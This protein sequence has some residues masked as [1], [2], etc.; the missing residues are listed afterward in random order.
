M[1][2]SLGLLLAAVVMAGCATPG[3]PGPQRLDTVAVEPL[4]GL[5][6]KPLTAQNARFMGGM[7][8]STVGAP[9][10][11]PGMAPSPSA[12]SSAGGTMS[13]NVYGGYYGYGYYGGGTNVPM[14]LVSIAEAE[15]PGSKGPLKQ[16]MADVVT[17]VLED[18]APDA[19]LVG[20]SGTLGNDGAALVPSPVPSAYPGFNASYDAGWRLSYVS[21][22][23]QEALNFTVMADKTIAIRMRWAPLNMATTP[24]VVDADEALKKLKA[25]IEDAQ[26]RS[27]EEETGL[28]YFLGTSFQAAM[29]MMTGS[30]EAMPPPPYQERIEPLYAVPANARW[31]VQLQAVLGKLV[32]ELHFYPQYDPNSPPMPQ[33]DHYVDATGRG[34]VDATTG[35]VIRFS[36]PSKRYYPQP[37]P[38]KGGPILMPNGPLSPPPPP[39][40][41]TTAPSLA[42]SVMPSA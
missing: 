31:N 9:M 42:P 3:V 11:A 24:I 27:E 34:M 16:I 26:A 14:A 30:R 2:P 20:S 23:R 15:A 41:P 36:R 6:F 32:W 18:W 25:A 17:P 33:L 38:G 29:P 1:R 12:L 40:S 19:H 39:P 22:S 7:P 13:G 4:G 35:T 28:D 5:T 10:V 37:F 8:G 21:P